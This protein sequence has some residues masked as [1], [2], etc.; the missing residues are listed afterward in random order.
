MGAFMGVFLLTGAASAGAAFL[1]F[2]YRF[3]RAQKII[4]AHNTF[5]WTIFFIASFLLAILDCMEV[6]IQALI[7][8]A[9]ADI[10]SVVLL[11]LN[12]AL[13]G[14]C[15]ISLKAVPADVASASENASS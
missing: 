13:L 2:L 11:T 12:L 1:W 9:A 5:V 3:A 7:P 14:W 4:I 6:M 8:A 15:I 10:A